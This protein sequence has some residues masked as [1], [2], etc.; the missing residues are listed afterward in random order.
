MNLGIQKFSS[1]LLILSKSLLNKCCTSGPSL[2]SSLGRRWLA[3][4]C[5]VFKAQ[6]VACFVLAGIVFCAFS[7]SSEFL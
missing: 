7:T 4:N 6:G 3:Q 5:H 2:L 1:W